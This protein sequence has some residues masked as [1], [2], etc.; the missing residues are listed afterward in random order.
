MQD[1]EVIKK[2]LFQ[3]RSPSF[4][5]RQGSIRWVTSQVLAR[6]FQTGLV[7]ITF[8]GEAE[9]AVRLGIRSWFA[10]MGLSTSDSILGLLSLFFTILSF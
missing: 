7:K 6:K 5:R 8:L 2:G 10:D 3:A 4:G 9:T 1:K